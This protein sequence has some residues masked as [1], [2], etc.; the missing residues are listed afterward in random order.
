MWQSQIDPQKIYCTQK[1]MK[2]RKK[3]PYFLKHEQ[4]INIYI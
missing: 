3:T 1:K 2:E 4:K